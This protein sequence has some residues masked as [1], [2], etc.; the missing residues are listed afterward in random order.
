MSKRSYLLSVMIALMLLSVH[1]VF[2]YQPNP[3]VESPFAEAMH[4][5]V[6]DILLSA[7]WSPKGDQ[8]ALSGEKGV[9]L[10]THDLKPIKVVSLDETS[11]I[12]STVW[13]PN[14]QQL[15]SLVQSKIGES[16]KVYIWNVADETILDTWDTGQSLPS[17]ISWSPDGAKIAIGRIIYNDVLIYDVSHRTQFEIHP[18]NN[19]TNNPRLV[20]WHPNSRWLGFGS[21][22]ILVWD[23]ASD[24]QISR[25]RTPTFGYMQVLSPDGFLAVVGGL[26]NN[27][28]DIP[29][30]AVMYVWPIDADRPL[31]TVLIDD[32]GEYLFESMAWNPKR[33]FLATFD[34]EHSNPET[35]YIRIWDTTTWQMAA[36]FPAA[37][38][39]YDYPLYQTLSWSPDGNELVDAGYGVVKIWKYV[40]N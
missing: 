15:A 29:A 30:Q 23:T 27:G 25:I 14:G 1:V 8:I 31:K 9:H 28:Y 40:G 3:T 10:Y 39:Y 21:A 24:K 26:I 33:P 7:A 2:A 37:K 36:K 32:Y 17:S 11:S 20:V 6:G 18:D 4:V 35:A 12:L 5:D 34:H 38:R 22:D 19:A 16:D 13:S